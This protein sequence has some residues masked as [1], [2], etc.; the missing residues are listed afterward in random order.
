MGFFNKEVLRDQNNNLI[1]AAFSAPRPL[2]AAAE[3]VNI[4]DNSEIVALQRRRQT[5]KWQDQAI[6]YYDLVGELKFSANLIA[7]VLSRVIIFPGYIT[8][9]SLV[10]AFLQKIEGVPDEL[11]KD[12]RDAL[13]LLGTGN[14]GVSGLL[15]DAALNIFLTGECYLVQQPYVPGSSIKEQWQI[16]SVKELEIDG[17]SKSRGRGQSVYIKGRRNMDKAS[18]IELPTSSFVGRIWNSHPAYSDEADSS[19]RGLLELLDELLLL[20]RAARTTA[21]SKLNAGLVGIPSSMDAVYQD[22]TEDD[23]DPSDPTAIAYRQEDSESIIEI[24]QATLSS[25][26]TDESAPSSLVPT[27]I[28]GTV[29]EIEA[30]RHIVFERPYDQTMMTRADKVLDR[31]LAGLDIP[32]E[33]VSGISDSKYANAVVIEETLFKSHIEPLAL[34]LVDSLTEVFLHPVLRAKGWTDEDIERITLWYDPAAITAKPSKAEA[35]TEGYNMG[36]L[37]K[38]AWRRAHGFSS[39][40]APT[41]LETGQRMAVERGMLSEPVT[42]ALLKTMLPELMASVRQEEIAASPGGTQLQEALNGDT[43][44]GVGEGGPESDNPGTETGTSGLLEP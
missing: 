26:I 5:D 14:G 38:D 18:R 40:D 9:D 24:L 27:M 25:P 12:A 44:P 20:N 28:R 39:S 35:A 17:A 13:R 3:R 19:V 30:I 37:S 4:S 33:I 11:K 31:I 1:P 7:S 34:L 15:R 36:V 10:P 43:I 8:E 41:E 22:D 21:R 2:T 6:E 16:R 23:I 42:E 29:E 32:K